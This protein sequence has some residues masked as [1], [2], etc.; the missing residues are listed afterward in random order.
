MPLK[1][2]GDPRLR[3]THLALSYP[4][5][6][7]AILMETAHGLPTMKPV[8]EDIKI[9][10]KLCNSKSLPSIVYTVIISHF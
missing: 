5:M 4:M 9:R 2:G 6:G 3:V 8:S 7:M 10:C 1:N